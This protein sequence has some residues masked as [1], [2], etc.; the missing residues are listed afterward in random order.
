[1]KRTKCPYFGRRLSYFSAFSEKKRG[2]FTCKGCGR[3][4][5]IF[6]SKVYKVLIAITVIVSAILVM[7]AI[8]P[9]YI[10][11]LWGMLLVAVPFFVLYL[12]TPF[13]LKLVPLKKNNKLDLD[14]YDMSMYDENTNSN[15][16]SNIY[17][18]ITSNTKIMSQIHLDDEDEFFDISDLN[19]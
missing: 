5:N 8:S 2:E 1:M 12:V 14:S 6:F 4:S 11:N 7:V 13:F 16:N 17:D 19:L 3:A 10:S 15:S 9:Q 18:D